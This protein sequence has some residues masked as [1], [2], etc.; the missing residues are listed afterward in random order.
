MTTV[1]TAVPETPALA[2]P[3]PSGLRFQDLDA[4]AY[5]TLLRD[6]AAIERLLAATAPLA[7]FTRTE[8]AFSLFRQL[9][10]AARGRVLHRWATDLD[11]DTFA[12]VYGLLHR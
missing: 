8:A 9:S 6:V 3:Q 4:D 10:S 11:P 2:A 12:R 7:L 1:Q 5:H